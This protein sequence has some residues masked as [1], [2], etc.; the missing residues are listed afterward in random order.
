M[1]SIYKDY[2]LPFKIKKEGIY[3]SVEKEKENFIYKRETKTEKIEK[4]L[5]TSNGKVLINPVEPLNK[6]KEITPYLL[7][8]LEKPVIIE[9][10]SVKRVFI[11]FPVEIG[12][13]IY[14]QKEFEVLD[15][16]SL[17]NQKFTLYGSVKDG[18]ICRYWKSKVYSSLPLRDPLKEGVMEL[19]IRNSMSSWI[20][21]SIAVFDAYGMKIYYNNRLVSMKAKMH[22]L[23]KELAETEFKPSPLEKGMS[24]SLE[25]YTVRKIPVIKKK[26]IMEW[27]I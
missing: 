15:I 5:L 17:V 13:F 9:P 23:G 1:Q 14:L 7:I 10:K 21:V 25:L 2:S 19:T 22:I 24:K 4:M 6:P 26:F 18:V 3:I 20:E 16:L 11:N 27:G 12:V 8:E